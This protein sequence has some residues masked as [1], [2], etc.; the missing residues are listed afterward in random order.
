MPIECAGR[1]SRPVAGESVCAD[2]I[3]I[4]RRLFTRCGRVDNIF[5]PAGADC[6]PD[7]NAI[8]KARILPRAH[9]FG[10]V[11]V[12]V[13]AGGIA[14]IKI[15]TPTRHGDY[16]GMFSEVYSKRALALAG[17]DA[18]FVQD[19]HAVSTYAGTLRGLHFQAPPFAQAKL[20]RVT[21]GRI[22]DVAVD[23]RKSSRTFGRHF[24]L[25]LSAANWRQVLVPVGFAHGY[26][27]LEANTEVLYK[28]TRDY[29]PDHECGLAWDDPVLGINWGMDADRAILSDK[30]RRNPY[31]ADLPKYFD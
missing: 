16:R 19:N 5:P 31:L 7:G 29:A 2:A 18:E 14:G 25:E 27:T 17:I 20:V 13:E 3:G 22:L 23:L 9:S 21:Q 10:A 28:V 12:K 24:A 4:R 11:M 26:M 6:C 8:A 30:D 15:I 1:S